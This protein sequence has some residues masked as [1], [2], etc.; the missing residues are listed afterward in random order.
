MRRHWRLRRRDRHDHRVPSA[1]IRRSPQSRTRCR[2]SAT[3]SASPSSTPVTPTGKPTR[4]TRS[5]VA[6]RRASASSRSPACS[7]TS[8]NGRLDRAAR[9]RGRRDRRRELG[10]RLSGYGQVA[11]GE[12]STACRSR[13][14]SSR[15]SGTCRRVRGGRLRSADD[16]RRV[17]RTDRPDQGRRQ[18]QAAVR[19][20]RVRRGQRVGRSPTGPRRWCSVRPAATSTT[21]G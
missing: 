14:T 3:R 10:R 6:T 18:G 15:S 13:P 20:H 2:R 4:D 1:T 21:S 8:P 17:H 16:V 12:P 9:P 11:D 19:R 5:K 7:P